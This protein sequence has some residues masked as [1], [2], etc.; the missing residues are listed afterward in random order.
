MTETNETL[1]RTPTLGAG[2]Y[3]VHVKER[4]RRS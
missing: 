4:R 2:M 3:G 1:P